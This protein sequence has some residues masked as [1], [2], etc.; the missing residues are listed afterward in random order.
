MGEDGWV[1]SMLRIEQE[2][3]MPF[4]PSSS[5]GSEGQRR[6]GEEWSHYSWDRRERCVLMCVHTAK[7][8]RHQLAVYR[9]VSR[10]PNQ[11]GP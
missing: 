8:P 9:A 1:A 4:V 10:K 6:H 2:W 11:A 3:S 7:A 5:S